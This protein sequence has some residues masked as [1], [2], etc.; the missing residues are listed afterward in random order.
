METPSYIKTLLKPN[1]KKSGERKVWS[2][3]LQ[4]VWLPFF[5][6]G[7]VQGDTAVPREALGA[8]LRLAKDK[9]GSVKFSKAGRPILKVAAELNDQIRLVRENFVSGLVTYANQVVHENP[10]GYK[11]ESEA[12]HEAGQPINEMAQADIQAAVDL[13]L[14]T[15]KAKAEAGKT[16]RQKVAVAA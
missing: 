11:A 4:T 5:V 10:E 7:N 12:C 13:V 2:I 6:A 3:G 9:D 14:E 1:A 8:P 16:K 15:A